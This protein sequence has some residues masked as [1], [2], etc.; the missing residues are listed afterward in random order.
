MSVRRGETLRTGVVIVLVTALSAAA[1]TVRLKPVPLR[2]AAVRNLGVPIFPWFGLPQTDQDGDLFFHVGGTTFNEASIMKLSHSSSAPTVYKLPPDIKSKYSF[3]E[4]TVTPGGIV[5]M[6]ANNMVPE[7][8]AVEFNAN[9]EVRGKTLLDL[10][11]NEVD[12]HGFSALDTGGVVIAGRYNNKAPLK[13]R[14]HSFLALFDGNSGKRIRELTDTFPVARGSEESTLAHQGETVTGDD[15]N[16]YVLDGSR[17]VVVRPGGEIGRRISFRK[18]D[19]ALLTMQVRV[20]G[21]AAAVW[22]GMLNNQTG[23]VEFSFLVLDLSNGRPIGWFTAPE[24]FEGQA[25]GF[26]RSAGF[27]FLRRKEGHF[28]IVATELR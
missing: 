22:L 9:G 1:P 6:L 8:V 24:G 4:F 7:L 26:S 23:T 20:S 25:V 2:V 10:D 18:P 13:L 21:G 15:G 16:I 3:D 17:M 14:S 28:E 27:Q 19:P 12:I 11:L 5:W